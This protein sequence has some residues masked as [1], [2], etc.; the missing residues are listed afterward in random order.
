MAAASVDARNE[1]RVPASRRQSSLGVL[2]GGV[3]SSI[4]D[5]EYV[6]AGAKILPTA[7]ETWEVA[8][9]VLKVKEPIAEECHRLRE[10]LTLFACLHLTA[11]KPLT[12]ELL[13]KKVTAIAYGT[14]Q[15][16]SGALPLLYP[17]SEV[18]GCLAG[19]VG[20]HSLM[21][22]EG[23][24]GVVMGG[25]GGVAIARVVAIGAGVAG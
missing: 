1:R 19:Q 6:A 12:E 15:L 23:A 5:E 20:A 18:A 17:M 25:V 22:A 14:V 4:N 3:G 13:N 2:G 8:D 16:P 10:D 9:L 24:R 7:D 11:D 21:K